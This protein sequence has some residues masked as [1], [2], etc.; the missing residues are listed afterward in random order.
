MSH[1]YRIRNNDEE[2]HFLTFSIVDWIDLFT[3]FEYK[4]LIVESLRYCCEHKGLEIYAYCLMT[5]HIHLLVSATAPAKLSDIVRDFKKHTNKQ[6]IKFIETEPE[7]RKDWILYRFQYHAKYSTRIE[8][9]KVW[10]DGYHS[11]VC[12]YPA[13][14]LQKLDYI[15][16]N[17]VKTGI[18]AMPEHYTYSSAGQYAGDEGVLK[19]TLLDV[20][21]FFANIN[22][23]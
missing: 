8:K 11:I 3:R 6:I 22:K 12:D 18:V 1:Q 9:Y 20:S 21:Y 13:I 15:H 23:R 2:I 7:S 19:V 4:Q 10:Q 16:N 14:L 17:P 5:N